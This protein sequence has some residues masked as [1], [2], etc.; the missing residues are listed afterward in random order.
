MWAFGFVGCI[1]F[2]KIAGA[3][4]SCLVPLYS[5]K[6][7]HLQKWPG[8]FDTALWGAEILNTSHQGKKMKNVV[9]GRKWASPGWMSRTTLLLSCFA[10]WQVPLMQVVLCKLQQWI[11]WTHI[12]M[13]MS[14]RVPCRKS[15]ATL[16]FRAFWIWRRV[17]TPNV[18]SPWYS[19]L[20]ITTSKQ[21]WSSKILLLDQEPIFLSFFRFFFGLCFLQTVRDSY[22]KGK[23]R[24][25]IR[26]PWGASFFCANL[27]KTSLARCPC[28][29]WLRR[30]AQKLRRGFFI[31]EGWLPPA[32]R[33]RFWT[34]FILRGRRNG[35]GT[36]GG[37]KR[38]FDWCR[39]SDTL[40]SVWQQDFV[41]RSIFHGRRSTE[42]SVLRTT[43]YSSSP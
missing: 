28:A 8:R 42:V 1:L 32:R 23:S 24:G 27:R 40:Q 35:F 41:L 15:T 31:V 10:V 37:R 39:T 36:F 14:G 4:V 19:A 25:L 38:H 11:V 13:S 17:K 21:S 18:C 43:P 9:V 5:T 29:F 16:G 6:A 20:G 3:W 26:V 34:K 30:L 2:F 12:D 7:G 22:G 33:V